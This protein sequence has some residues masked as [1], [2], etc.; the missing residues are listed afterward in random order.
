MD[1]HELAGADVVL[2]GLGIETTS[3][4]PH[5]HAA[6][7]G[8]I[9]I[10][11]ATP[12]RPDQAELLG[13]VGVE[14]EDIVVDTPTSADVVLRSPGFPAYRD[15]VV[16]LCQNARISTTPTGLWIAVRGGAR[17]IAVTGTK[18][19]SSTLSLIAAGLGHLG[20]DNFTAGNIGTPAWGIDPNRDGVAVMEL[21]SY[22]GADLLATAQVTVLTLLAEDHVDWHGSLDAYR[23][24]KLRILGLD[25]ADGSPPAYRFAPVGQDLDEPLASQVTWVPVRGDYRSHNI[26]LAVAAVR[27]ERELLGEPVPDEDELTDVLGRHYPELPSR[28]ERIPTDDGIDWIDDALGSNPSATAA[29]LE[30]IKPGPAVLIC[31]G[32][33]RHVSLDPVNAVLRQWPVDALDVV[34]L[35]D[36]DDHRL[37]ELTAQPSV[38]THRTA[39]SIGEAVNV[40][41]GLASARTATTRPTVVFSPLAP[42][43]RSEGNWSD[44]SRAFQAAIAAL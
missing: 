11:E 14:S 40:A 15:D 28:F 27:A 44:R 21:S 30:R 29:A 25:Q 34:W 10:A 43:E 22:H 16:T 2:L 41:A 9:R 20:V 31:G 37:A 17:T 1:L 42:T 38:A 36:R 18:G 39:G 12:L 32:H 24:D 7:V 5:L 13:Q 4:L 26:A 19:K 33:D 35:G 6:G 8:R 3:V 23:R